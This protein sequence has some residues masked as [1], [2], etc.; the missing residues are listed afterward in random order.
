MS[1]VLSPAGA[2]LVPA[3]SR[4]TCVAVS[5]SPILSARLPAVAVAVVLWVARILEG[6]AHRLPLGTAALCTGNEG[7]GLQLGTGH[8]SIRSICRIHGAQDQAPW[9]RRPS[10]TMERALP[11]GQVWQQCPGSWSGCPQDRVGHSGL[12]F[13]QLTLPRPL[14]RRPH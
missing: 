9:S 10:L 2:A 4:P 14:A 3:G 8:P 11:W 1:L 6:Q 12:M 13:L 7:H 5:T